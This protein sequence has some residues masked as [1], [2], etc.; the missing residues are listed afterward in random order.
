M[1]IRESGEDYLEAILM[2]QKRNGQVRS[3][4]IC[5]E[6]GFS[7][8]TVSVAMKNFRENGY[9]NMDEDYLITL[10]EKGRVIAESVYERHVVI[11]KFLSAIGV[12]EKT[13]LEDA[14]KIEHDLSDET[15]RCMKEH[16]K[17]ISE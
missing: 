3:I 10:T 13:A 6:L 5:N 8:P 12:D 17:K 11:A 16:Y 15:F 4:D 14:C 1:Q 7:K 9:I 2:L